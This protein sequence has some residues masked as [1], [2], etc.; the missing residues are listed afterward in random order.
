M[1]V[2]VDDLGWADVQ[3]NNPNSFYETK[4][5][6]DLAKDGVLFTNGYASC[7]V[8]SPSRAS[9]M[10]GKYPARLQITDWIPGQDPKN[11]KLLGPQDIHN[12]P[13]EEKTIAEVLKENGYKTGFFGKWH[14]G[15]T[16]NFWPENQGFD[17]NV[18]GWSKGAPSSY[19]SPYKNPKIEES[20]N[21]EY[22]P[23]RLTN[24][25]INFIEQNK[26]APFFAFLSFYTVHTPIQPSKRHLEYYKKKKENFE[27]DSLAYRQEH[28][29][30]TDL[31]QDNTN[32]ASMVHA[33]DENVGR[34]V[35]KLKGLGL[36]DN[37]V[38]IF[39][40]DNGGLSTKIQG[41]NPTSNEPLRAGKGWCYEGG[42][43]VP[44]IIY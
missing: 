30:I 35:Q 23:D 38:I 28:E 32:Y 31:L 20:I 4:N 25:T 8:C 14:L 15:E 39:T 44:L 27:F 41:D 9:I 7:P 29:G 5:I 24:E 6:D 33:M 36:Y 43:R 10:T 18:G 12:L 42:I 26:G 34:L 2:L 16:E 19:Y 1:F 17:V 21:G 11:R 22:L 3:C 40:S 13:L 37:T